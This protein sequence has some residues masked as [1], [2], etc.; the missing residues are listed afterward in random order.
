MSSGREELER[1]LELTDIRE[2]KVF[3]EALE[4]GMEKG[5]EQALERVALRSLAKGYSVADVS[6]LTGLSVPRVKR[7]K[8]KIDSKD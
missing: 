3:Q 5:M 8:K 1:M 2:T 4:E 6:E 7:L